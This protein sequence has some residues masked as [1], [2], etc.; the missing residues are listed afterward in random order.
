MMASTS[1]AGIRASRTRAIFAEVRNAGLDDDGRRLLIKNMTG[2][3]SIK[4]CT[5]G[6]LSDVLDHL[7]GRQRTATRGE[8]GFVFDL[9]KGKQ[10]HLKK[11]YRLAQ[12]IGPK[13]EPPCTAAPVRYIEGIVARTRGL[14]GTGVATPLAMCPPEELHL[15]VQILET[16]VRRIGA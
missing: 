14:A 1:L 2:R 4:D 13:M 15:I 5:L 6:E 9:P 8:W 10:T 12:R 3:D 7:R 11:I 16:Y